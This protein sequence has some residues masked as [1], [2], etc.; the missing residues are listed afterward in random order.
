[1][2]LNCVDCDVEFTSVRRL[3]MAV[4]LLAPLPPS[5]L[6]PSILEMRLKPASS[7]LSISI[8]PA[9]VVSVAGPVTA[10]LAAKYASVQRRAARQLDPDDRQ[11]LLQLIDRQIGRRQ[12]QINHNSLR[13]KPEAALDVHGNRAGMDREIGDLSERASRLFETL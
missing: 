4:P 10:R 3:W 11:Q 5:G 6:S 9:M 8:G 1:M 13:R 7:V 12:A 2:L